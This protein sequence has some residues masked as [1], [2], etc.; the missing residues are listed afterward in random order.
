M[1]LFIK[2]MALYKKFFEVV[3]MNNITEFNATSGVNIVQF[4]LP[5]VNGATLSTQDLLFSGNL[6]VN[7]DS[8]DPYN[9][10]DFGDEGISMD[11][12]NGIHNLIDRVDIISMRGNTLVEQRLN[13]QLINKYQRGVQAESNLV[14]GR[15]NNQQLCSSAVRGTRNFLG[16]TNLADDGQDFAMQLNTGLMKNN[17]QSLNLGALGGLMVKVYLTEPINAFFNI[18]P[19]D[20][21]TLIGNDFTYSL[22]NVKLFGRYNYMTPEVINQ[23]NG[24]SY[25]K[26][27]NL[28]SV[29]QSSNDTISNMP[30]VMALHKMIYVYQPNNE[31]TNNKDVNNMAVNMVCGLDKYLLSTNGTRMPLDYSVDINPTIPQ[32]PTTSGVRS[33]V[34]GNA[35]QQYLAIS[36]LNDQ[37]PPTHSLSNAKN[38]AKAL[39]D[40]LENINES[41]L[42]VDVI[43]MNY[44]F[45]F[46]GYSVAVPNDLMSIN[47]ESSIKTSDNN[48]PDGTGNSRDIRDQS[49]TQNLFI[50]YDAQ[51]NYSGMTTGR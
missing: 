50:E 9:A 38:Q 26:T 4:L 44:S 20:A 23:L 2:T 34:S 48:L 16:R 10:A 27:D 7:L 51:L 45:N 47:V 39:N 29:I 46:Q 31:T 17:N 43:G 11:S 19:N 24:V 40:Q 12:V 42:N 5:A 18:D 33:R 37:F 36:A 8:T 6:Q 15:F 1:I 21:G 32:L 14:N 22:R 49:A 41:T 3:P 35:E 13:Y 28:M 25:R 30:Q